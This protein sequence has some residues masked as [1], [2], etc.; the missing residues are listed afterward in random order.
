M[1]FSREYIYI[2]N[3]FSSHPWTLIVQ[4][5]AVC[6]DVPVRIEKAPVFPHDWMISAFILLMEAFLKKK[7]AQQWCYM[8]QY[9]MK[10]SHVRGDCTCRKECMP[11]HTNKHTYTEKYIFTL[12]N[13]SVR[14]Q[15]LEERKSIDYDHTLTN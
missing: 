10:S 9:K 3:I 15:K 13:F 4:C 12:K 8:R 5:L 6:F 2:C 7:K 14:G 11:T 1:D